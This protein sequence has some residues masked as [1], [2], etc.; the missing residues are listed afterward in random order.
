MGLTQP[1]VDYAA[2][3]SPWQEVLLNRGRL[4]PRKWALWTSPQD[5][6]LCSLRSHRSDMKSTGSQRL[7]QRDSNNRG[8]QLTNIAT[9]S[10]DARSVMQVSLGPRACAAGTCVRRTRSHR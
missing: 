5:N 2:T 3:D 9:A 7:Y 8:I 6:N 10:G 1:P 4:S